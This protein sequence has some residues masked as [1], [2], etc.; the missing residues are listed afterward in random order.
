MVYKII[1]TRFNRWFEET[2]IVEHTFSTKEQA[3][4]L[5]DGKHTIKSKD[6]VSRRLVYD[7]TGDK[8]SVDGVVLE[9]TKYR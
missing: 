8:T 3:E 7:K 1:L 4:R 2:T 9:E 6:D 5:F